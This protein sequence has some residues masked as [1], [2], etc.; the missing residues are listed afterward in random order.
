MKAK[1][2]ERWIRALTSGKYKKT[3]DELKCGD[4]SFCALGVLHEVYRK[5]TKKGE[6]IWDDSE[7]MYKFKV[8]KQIG[9]V[10]RIHPSVMKWAGT[11]NSRAGI[12]VGV[13]Y[14]KVD[15]VEINDDYKWSFKRIA[16]AIREQF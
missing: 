2:K 5:D 1:I 10:S 7:D 16:K 12:D 13:D 11:K 14:K 8:G 4:K 6:W 3:T 9:D 15:M